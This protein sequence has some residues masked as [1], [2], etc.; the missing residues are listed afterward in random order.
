MR[1]P[2]HNPARRRRWHAAAT[3]AATAALV[4]GAP[5][6]AHAS[7]LLSARSGVAQELSGTLQLAKKH[8]TKTPTPKVTGTARV[9]SK[10][11]AKPGT[12]APA[13]VTLT[14]R[15]YRGSSPIS[16]ATKTTYTLTKSDAGKKISVRVTGKRTGYVSVTKASAAR[17][18][19][20]LLTTTPTP[21]IAG[22]A[23]VGSTLTARAGTWLPS[24]VTLTYR[25]YRGSAAI[26]GA[27]RLTYKLTAADGGQKV[28]VRVTGSRAGYTSVTRPSAAVSV[29]RTLTATPVPTVAGSPGVGRTLTAVPG[30]WGPAPVT[31]TYQWLRDGSA[32][33]GATR[34]TYTATASDGAHQLAVRVTGAKTG[35]VSVT[36]TSAQLYVPG[37][38]TRTPVPTILGSATVGTTLILD[39]GAWDTGVALTTQWL[40]NGN[41]INGATGF[42]YTITDTDTGARLSVRVT[43]SRGG[44]TPVTRTSAQTQPVSSIDVI[45][46]VLTQDTT[47]SADT[48]PVVVIS[49]LRVAAGAT[50]TIGPGVVVKFASQLVTGDQGSG[51]VVDGDLAINGTAGHP[52]V[53][54]VL[55]DDTVGGDTNHDGDDSEPYY[56]AWAHIE[57]SGAVTMHHTDMRWARGLFINQN[58]KATSITDSAFDLAGV[59]GGQVIVLGSATTTFERNTL[60]GYLTIYGGSPYTVRDNTF[61]RIA[62]NPVAVRLNDLHPAWVSGNTATND[63]VV[64]MGRGRLTEDWTIP[65]AEHLQYASSSID[66]APGTQVTVE[67]GATLQASTIRVGGRF[68]AHGTAS[69]PITIGTHEWAPQQCF[70][71]IDGATVVLEHVTLTGE[72]GCSDGGSVSNVDPQRTWWEAFSDDVRIAA[73]TFPGALTLAGETLAVTGTRAEGH[74]ELNAR[75]AV[76]AASNVVSH[77]D[78]GRATYDISGTLSGASALAGNTATNA[79]T[80]S[81]DVTI[82]DDWT[83]P[84]APGTNLT[85]SSVGV[86]VQADRGAEQGLTVAAGAVIPSGYLFSTSGFITLDGTAQQ[87]I[88]LTDVNLTAYSSVQNPHAAHAVRGH[89][90]QLTGRSYIEVWDSELAFDNT[91]FNQTEDPGNRPNDYGSTCIYVAGDIFPGSYRGTLSGCDVGVHAQTSSTFDA[92][93]VDWGP[94]GPGPVGSGPVA[95]GA[96]LV[97]PWAGYVA[98]TVP[99]TP[100]PVQPSTALTCAPQLLVTARG[101]GEVPGGSAETATDPSLYDAFAYDSTKGGFGLDYRGMGMR[102]QE[103]LTGETLVTD[104]WHVVNGAQPALLDSLTPT[105]RASMQ[106]YALRYAATS[107]DVPMSAVQLYKTAPFIEL[108]PERLGEYL[109][110]ILVGA[111]SMTDL[112]SS[113]ATRCPD[114][115]FVL[116]GYSQGAMV[117][118]MA[119]SNLPADKLEQLAPRIDGVV[120]LADPLRNP[121]DYITE[122]ST[123]TSAGGGMVTEAL[124]FPAAKGLMDAYLDAVGGQSMSVP[125]PQ[126]LAGRTV[127][128]CTSGDRVCDPTAGD[129]S[130]DARVAIH[131]YS[132]G[133]LPEWGRHIA[134]MLW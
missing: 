4:L 32:I 60:A 67:P 43:G 71:A 20:R 89:H 128:I 8:L 93:Y 21:T 13:P 75:D 24:P 65:A 94:G 83:L 84:R 15:W 110:S 47:W 115:H 52:V 53:L 92:R 126:E 35:Y 19:E 69:A 62:D 134:E 90:V 54:T 79:G 80:M 9:G 129:L 50:L 116:A 124:A 57:A 41:P 18:V 109:V 38:L 99:S 70:A 127:S 40:R 2:P 113:Q 3:F 122:L 105:Q 91:T 46:G 25:W 132:S 10:L 97:S 123:A 64:D 48:T 82:H 5:A 88:Q 16:G 130:D 118:H 12:W 95:L 120:L 1:Q 37:T 81:I 107:V 17:T 11:T 51:L 112:L 87:P 96:V 31:F 117:I 39:T 72:P 29:N 119:L 102:L 7:P 98:P 74:I 85:W 27:T 101:S 59:W 34:S 36:R 26:S 6:A 23:T 76:V 125:Y 30:S 77:P 66:I 42:S 55:E 78:P 103:L 133:Q 86:V 108:H 100:A 121:D 58:P 106:V 68:I 28:S 22:T 33:A 73:S 63:L 61:T 131:G 104:P 14:Y 44:Y 45:T 111:H 49:Q 114:Q 56:D